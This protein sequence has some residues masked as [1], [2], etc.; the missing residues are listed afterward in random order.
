MRASRRTPYGTPRTIYAALLGAGIVAC[1]TSIAGSDEV[2]QAPDIVAPEEVVPRE[3]DI[4]TE[5]P[6]LPPMEPVQSEAT[7]PQLE[8]QPEPQPEP[9]VLQP[10]PDDG[11][12]PRREHDRARDAV[13]DGQA[14][15]L[16]NIIRE[17]QRTC[18]GTFLNAILEDRDGRLVYRLQTLSTAGRRLF[19]IVDAA[20]GSV[21]SGG[22]R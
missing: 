7:E 9:S 10:E 4:Q 13:R 14:L 5:A 8:P 11:G 6:V 22:C 18:P 17:L 19:T 15:P 20:T 1:L 12:P 21:V 2:A 3:P 16:G